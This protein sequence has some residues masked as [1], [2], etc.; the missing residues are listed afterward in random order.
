MGWHI[1]ITTGIQ[2]WWQAD[3]EFKAR[4]SQSKNPS[5]KKAPNFITICLSIKRKKSFYGNDSKTDLFEMGSR[6]VL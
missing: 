4:F 3:H 5:S 2:R 6:E 1:Q